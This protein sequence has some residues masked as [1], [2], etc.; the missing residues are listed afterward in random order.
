MYIEAT[1]AKVVIQEEKHSNF[2]FNKEKRLR[3][4]IKPLYEKGCFT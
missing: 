3:K 4:T 1:H 2:I